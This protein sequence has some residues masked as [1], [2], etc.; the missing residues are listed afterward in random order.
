M[1]TQIVTTDGSM[2]AKLHIT[3]VFLRSSSILI[4]TELSGLWL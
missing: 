1:N 2:G 3:A 4:P